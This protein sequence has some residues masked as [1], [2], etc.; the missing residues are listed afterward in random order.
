MH[1]EI[2]KLKISQTKPAPSHN[3]I[4]NR[5]DILRMISHFRLNSKNKNDVSIE[6][7]RQLSNLFGLLE[8]NAGKHVIQNSRIN[9]ICNFSKLF[10]GRRPSTLTLL[11]LEYVLYVICLY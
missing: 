10:G 3:K 4:S 9:R 6:T 1:E 7:I 11:L 2:R 8:N 5:F